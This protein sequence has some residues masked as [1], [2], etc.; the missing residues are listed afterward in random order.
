MPELSLN[1]KDVDYLASHLTEN[2]LI[3][4]LRNHYVQR[5]FQIQKRWPS[6]L[7]S[8]DKFYLEFAHIVQKALERVKSSKP[9]PRSV[10]NLDIDK[11]KASIDI[12]RFISKHTRLRQSGK[13]YSGICPFHSEQHPSFTV[14]PESQSWYCFSCN[15]G[16]DVINFIM[17]IEKVEFKSA[18]EILTGG[19][20]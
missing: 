13:T 19:N 7:D 17:L 20:P 6:C 1:E 14:Y 10:I 2:Q 5:A 11:T 12:V 15:R 4:E 9:K 16:G 3:L 8:E 18:L